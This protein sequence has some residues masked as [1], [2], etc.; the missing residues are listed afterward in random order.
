MNAVIIMSLIPRWYDCVCKYIMLSVRKHSYNLAF[1]PPC[2]QCHPILTLCNQNAIV[3]QTLPLM[4][5]T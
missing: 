3:D 5:M 1:L 2:H 4:L